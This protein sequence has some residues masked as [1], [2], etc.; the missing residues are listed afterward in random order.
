MESEDEGAKNME[1]KGCGTC[2]KQVQPGRILKEKF[3][4]HRLRTRAYIQRQ[5]RK[6]PFT[7]SSSYPMNSR[8][9][10]QLSQ[11]EVE[12]PSTPPQGNYKIPARASHHQ[13]T[14]QPRT[15]TEATAVQ[16]VPDSSPMVPA[17]VVKKPMRSSTATKRV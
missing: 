8:P 16:I 10:A 2:S 7:Q 4:G 15:T 6:I 14:K 1:G 13:S 17:E 9:Y 3:R 11:C 12:V 5:Q